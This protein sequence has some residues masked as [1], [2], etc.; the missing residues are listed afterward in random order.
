M[1][2]RVLHVALE[3]GDGQQVREIRQLIAALP[4]EIASRLCVLQSERPHGRALRRWSRPTGDA[5]LA[6][7]W[8]VAPTWRES[9]DPALHAVQVRWPGDP[10]A[11]WQLRRLC[12]RLQPDVVHAWGAASAFARWAVPRRSR[13]LVTQTECASLD[14]RDNTHP[15]SGCCSRLGRRPQAVAIRAVGDAGG[16]GESPMATES[17]DLATPRIPP[18]VSKLPSVVGDRS[19][20]GDLRARWELPPQAI[21]AVGVG[22]WDV[23][24]RW[25][26]AF[27]ALEILGALFADLHLVIM[28]DGPGAGGLYKLRQALRRGDRVHLLPPC[29]LGE[30]WSQ[31]DMIWQPFVASQA[32]FALLEAMSHGVPPLVA[33]APTIRGVVRDGETGVLYPA[34]RHVMLCKAVR[35]LLRDEAWR[36]ELSD[37][38]RR[39]V[40]T[41]FS[42]VTAAR[43]YESLYRSLSGQ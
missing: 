7:D 23:D 32:P 39:H 35:R 9:R 27:W 11:I 37:G 21:L 25:S 1:T 43:R 18:G 4:S 8:A 2:V 13:Y 28:G 34:G 17:D 19:A 16:M 12:R 31:V 15:T 30:A 33:D 26:D 24:A 42:G 38:A 10:L 41:H 20:A 14:A 3:Q 29:E 22:R 40:A 5:A 36:R 6:G